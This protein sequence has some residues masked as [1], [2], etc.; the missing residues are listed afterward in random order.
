MYLE[1]LLRLAEIIDHYESS[2]E[3]LISEK[4]HDDT[5]KLM[6]AQTEFLKSELEFKVKD[7][8]P[9][10][11]GFG[12]LTITLFSPD[13]TGEQEWACISRKDDWQKS[14]R[15]NSMLGL[16]KVISLS[17]EESNG[18]TETEKTES[19]RKD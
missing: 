18:S 6:E 19:E 5:K 13:Q 17:I 1:S 11:F 12:T 3:K 15:F 10:T 7:P 16:I 9:Y 4:F 8:G 14:Y 2:G